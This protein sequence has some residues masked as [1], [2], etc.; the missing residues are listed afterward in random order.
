MN[1][2]FEGFIKIKKS[3]KY[4]DIK[5]PWVEKYRP[6][7]SD[8]ILLDPFIKKKIDKD[9]DLYQEMESYTIII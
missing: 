1:N 3:N 5:L 6:T 8:D 9:G 4:N 2:M 7:N